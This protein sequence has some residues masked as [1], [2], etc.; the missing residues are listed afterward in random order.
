MG[1]GRVRAILHWLTISLLTF[2]FLFCCLFLGLRWFVTTYIDD[3]R[4]DITEMVSE[5]TGINIKASKFSIGFYYIWPTVTLENVELSRPGGPVSLTLPLVQGQLSWSSLWHFEPRFRHFSIQNPNLTVRRLSDTQI[6]VA[7]FVLPIPADFSP[8]HIGAAAT[9]PNAGLDTRLTA[10]LLAQDRLEL[11]NGSVIYLDKEEHPIRLSDVDF[12]FEQE[13]L[14]WRTAIRGTAHTDAVGRDF[15]LKTIINKNL[16]LHNGDPKNWTGQTYIQFAKTD[17]ARLVSKFGLRRFFTSGTAS[18]EMWLNFENG[19]VTRSTIDLA[20]TGLDLTLNP[21]LPPL[22]IQWLGTRLNYETSH[23]DTVLRK[24]TVENLDF[25]TEN[26]EH[27]GNTNLTI[28]ARSDTTGHITEGNL[29]ASRIDFR[30]LISIARRL[31]I[32]TDVREFLQKHPLTGELANVNIG[33]TGDPQEPANWHARSSF[34]NLSLPVGHDTIPGF[35]GLSGQIS[36]LPQTGGFGLTLDSHQVRLTFPGVFRRENIN[37]DRLYSTL[38]FSFAPQPTLKVLSLEAS[39]GEASVTAEGSWIGTGGPGTLN[40]TGKILRG[41]AEAVHHY[42]PRIL[43]EKLLD[44]LEAGILDGDITNGNY[45]VEGPLTSFPWD[46]TN[47]GKG[48]FRIVADVKHGKLDFLPSHQKNIN[49]EW[50]MESEYPILRDIDAHL[51]FEGN[52]MDIR[53]KSASS[54][55]LQASDIVVRIP[56]YITDSRL[57]IEGRIQG[58]L[59]NALG[60]VNGSHQLNQILSGAFLQSQGSGKADMHLKLDMP[61]SDPKAIKVNLALSLTDAELQYGYG[62]PYVKHINGNLSITEKSVSTPMPIEG[63]TDAGPLTVN[64]RTEDN[65]ITLMTQGFVTSTDLARLIDLNT[66]TPFLDQVSGKTPVLVQTVIGLKEPHL[67]VSGTSDLIGLSSALPAPYTKTDKESWPLTFNWARHENGHVLDLHSFGHASMTLRF[68][69]TGDKTEWTSGSIALGLQ[70]KIPVTNDQINI[71]MITP[72]LSLNDWLPYA[73][74]VDAIL[75]K[76]SQTIPPEVPSTTAERSPMEKLGTIRLLTDELKWYD[77]RY[78]NV[79][80]VLRQ[81]NQKNWHLRIGGN[82]QLSGSVTYESA[83]DTHSDVLTFKFGHLHLPVPTDSS[84][85]QTGSVR[86]ASQA[87]PNLPDMTVVIDDLRIGDMSIG[88]VVAHAQNRLEKQQQ[89]W[90]IRRLDIFNRGGKISGQGMWTHAPGQEGHTTIDVLVDIDNMGTVLSSLSVE[91]AMKGAPT[92]ASAKLSWQGMPFK[93]RLETLSGNVTSESGSGSFLQIEPG[94]GRL[95]SLLSMQHLLHRLTLD[96]R[97]V[98][99]QGFTF[100]SLFLS[101]T[102]ENGL[103]TIPKATVFGSAATVVLGGKADIPNETLDAKAVIL[104]AINAAGPSLALALVNPAV[105]IGTFLTQLI[106]KD[107][108]SNIFRVEYDIKGTFDN[109]IL[110]KID[111]ANK[112]NENRNAA[113]Q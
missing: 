102:V 60:Y 113:V 45:R 34:K 72:T 92:H 94:A 37:L 86:S 100:D 53:G 29:Q 90:D 103:L 110:T 40:L 43:G 50:Q 62:L 80:A 49:G 39:N 99:S 36:P 19:R 20:L 101:G 1:N 33:F 11:I 56:S 17:I 107:Q 59:S 81:F 44:W 6:D 67:S 76:N 75:R 35:S 66:A 5:A 32:P 88:K 79:E 12:I 109:P 41:K 16:F 111:L 55:G 15:Q 3:Y 71:A 89:Y 24:L 38:E 2:Y 106:L 87:S 73:E 69:K 112:M 95:L 64:I 23:S 9:V 93:P 77:K 78:P 42:I 58:D 74:K 82:Q 105:G 25:L 104:P 14:H 97:D 61:F 30:P 7:G 108:L 91:N 21:E 63:Q 22:R 98:L 26:N 4:E 84:S 31:P 27:L 18:T 51:L 57:L 28:S 65:R 54:E 13:L 47:Q 96:F 48:L 46:N 68:E 83:T 10:W 70:R 8:S 85:E 52:S